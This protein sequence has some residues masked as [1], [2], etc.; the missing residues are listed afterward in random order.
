MD[1]SS[2]YASE[3]A[4]STK[5][6]NILTTSSNTKS[7]PRNQSSAV[8]AAYAKSVLFSRRK[9]TV[10]PSDDSIRLTSVKTTIII[11]YHTAILQYN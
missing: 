8:A 7:Y 2:Y 5:S 11:Y 4:K 3:T 6:A 9:L 1:L 10:L